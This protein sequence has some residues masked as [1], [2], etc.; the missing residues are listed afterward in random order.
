MKIY[1]RTGDDGTTSLYGG[2]RLS[3]GDLRVWAYGTVD[4][5]N[6]VIGVARAQGL[7]AEVDAVLEGVQRDLF[8]LGAEL[9]SG[10]N[11]EAKL[12]MELIGHDDV[13]KLEKAIDASEQGLEPLK[14]FILPGGCVSAALLHV[15]RTTV[16]RAERELVQLAGESNVRPELVAYANRLSDLL[17]VLARHTNH[18]QGTADVPWEPRRR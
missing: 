17:F 7:P 2:R 13:E 11:A 9:A 6:S 1:T 16:R 18:A 12:N 15:A 5:A 4:E 14:T 3:K 10:H 8:V